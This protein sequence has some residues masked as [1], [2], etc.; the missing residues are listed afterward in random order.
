MMRRAGWP[1]V[2][3]EDLRAKGESTLVGGPF[4]SDLTQND[5][6][7]EPG[8]PVIRGTNLGGKESRFVD[9][10]F[11]Y[12][13]TEKAAKLRRN[14]A[15]PGD[16]IFTQRGTLGQIA[17]IPKAAKFP[18]YIISQSQMKLTPD[19]SRID[20]RFLY[21]YFRTPAALRRLLGQTQATGVPHINLGILKRFAVPVPPLDEQRRIA[22]VLDRAEALRAKRRAALAQLD[23]LTQ[24][25]FLDLFGDPVENRKAWPRVPFETL[26]MAIESGW[27]PTCLDRG[28]VGEEWGVLKL[29]AVSWCEFDPTENKA[30]PPD[31]E[32]DPR[33]E[34]GVGDLLFARKNTYDLVGACVLVRETPPRLMI[35]DLVFRFRLKAD[36]AVDPCFLQQL[37]IYPTKRRDI[38]KL[39]GGTSGSMPNISKGR[40]QAASIELPPLKLQQD[41]AQR[42][43]A[44]EKLKS[45][46]RRSLAELDALFASLQ[47]RAFRG[48]L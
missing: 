17:I 25:I 37:L 24:S 42:I 11:V 22:E 30:L 47:H 3:I 48:E 1:E 26:L 18:E 39:A 43:A 12:V 27:S 32:P 2:E 38:Q 8:V 34:V 21:Q 46:Q 44:V 15:F 20:A 28:V 29:G 41:F 35:P 19:A 4:G 45:A 31:V 16:V 13:T 14:M 9:D 5:Y 33:L 36:A 40:L 23:T 10:G 6:V 7:A